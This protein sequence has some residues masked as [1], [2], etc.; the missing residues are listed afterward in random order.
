MNK[1]WE[2]TQIERLV[3]QQEKKINEFQTNIESD[4]SKNIKN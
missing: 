3:A 2:R 4:F 1:D